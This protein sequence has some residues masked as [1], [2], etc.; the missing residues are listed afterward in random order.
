MIVAT[1]NIILSTLTLITGI[2]TLTFL[3]Y[4]LTLNIN[5]KKKRIKKIK[6]FFEQK[7]A[8]IIF[9]LALTATLGS[10]F[11]SEIAKYGV[12]TL[13]WY[14]R[15][16]MYPLVIITGLMLKTKSEELI[17]TTKIMTI[18]GAIIA[19]YHYTIQIIPTNVICDANSISCATK[20]FLTFGY[21]SIPMMSLTAFIA[22]IITTIMMKK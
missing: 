1:T 7:G 10:L 16:F 8:I 17:Q 5:N 12:C 15:I 14:Q 3:I 13:C 22:I 6:K 2:S 19:L 4:Y 9:T 20:P 18:I 11:Y 21:I